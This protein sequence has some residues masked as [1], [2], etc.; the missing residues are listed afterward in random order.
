[1]PSNNLFLLRMIN[2][3]N[4]IINGSFLLSP[5]LLFIGRKDNIAGTKNITSRKDVITPIET[6]VP[7]WRN[8]GTSEKFMVKKPSAVVVLVNVIGRKFI[9]RVSWILLI[10]SFPE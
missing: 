6:M 5:C 7:R 8:G 2:L 4:E 10:R 9:L 3:E 1:M